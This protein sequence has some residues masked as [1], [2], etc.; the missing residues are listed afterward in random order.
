LSAQ[1]LSTQG[2]ASLLVS[3]HQQLK[4]SNTD[5]ARLARH[6]SLLGWWRQALEQGL[7]KDPSIQILKPYLALPEAG[8]GSDWVRVV[9]WNVEL[10][11]R[12]QRYGCFV[13]T[14]GEGLQHQVIELEQ[15]LRAK[16]WAPT[17]RVAPDSWPGAIYYEVILNHHRRK[18]YYT[19]L[20]WDGADALVTRK[21][22]EPIDLNRGRV[23]LGNRN[24]VGQNG[25]MN[26][27]VLEYADDA[28]VALRYEPSKE[29]IVMDHLSPF[30]PHLQ[31]STAFYG[32]DM[33]YD[34]LIWEKG[35]WLYAP[36]VEVSDPKLNAPYIAPP[37]AR[38][39]RGQ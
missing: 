19:L 15:D 28:N 13:V 36:D 25:L 2:W 20:G 3:G 7:G 33:S 23:R 39:R 38:R 17:T 16:P 11:D 30:E 12:S 32:P 26:R 35:N 8:T 5:E 37:N 4:E 6:D 24:I 34:A 31:G 10:S 9:S 18:P 27:V 29:R 22:I 1:S 14:I 21:L